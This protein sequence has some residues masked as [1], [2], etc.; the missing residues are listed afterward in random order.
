MP[1]MPVKKRGSYQRKGEVKGSLY[2][3]GRIVCSIYNCSVKNWSIVCTIV[4]Y[5]LRLLAGDL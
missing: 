4:S 3:V 2:A 1:M 5:L